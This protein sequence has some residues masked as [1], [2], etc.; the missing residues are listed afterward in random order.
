MNQCKTKQMQFTESTKTK[1]QCFI[2]VE[3]KKT[4]AKP[5]FFFVTVNNKISASPSDPANLKH[6]R[7]KCGALNK[8]MFLF[9]RLFLRPLGP[10]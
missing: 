8:S 2:H 3:E 7:K 1:D 4:R 6:G 9:E 5:F 10:N